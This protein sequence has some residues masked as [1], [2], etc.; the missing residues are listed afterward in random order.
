M[1]DQ[2]ERKTELQPSLHVLLCGL[3][4]LIAC[5]ILVTRRPDAIFH[6]QFFAE[7]GHVWYAEAYNLGWLTTLFRAQDGYFQTLPRLAGALAQLV[8]L[9]L[10]PM[11]L[12]LIAIAVEAIPVILLL[13]TRSSVWGSL[14]FRALLACAYL[15]LPNSREMIAILTSSQWILALSVFLLLAASTPKGVAVRIFDIS[16]LLLSGLTGP[17]CFFLFPVAFFLAWKRRGLWRFAEAGLLAAL[18]AVQAWGLLVVD[19]SGR[20]H[21]PLGAGF[22]LFTRLLASQIFL[23]AL[24]GG[25]A[26]AVNAGP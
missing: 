14:H 8:P 26:L 21:A 9:A 24:F 16:I 1:Q 6:A 17:F 7:D 22:G 15:V 10:A 12:N 13:S 20:A 11:V 2:P 23:G 3:A 4:F 25:N 5:A 18:C 19:P